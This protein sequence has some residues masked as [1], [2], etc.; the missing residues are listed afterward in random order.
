VAPGIAEGVAL[1]REAIASGRALAK[2]HQFIARTQ[3][4]ARA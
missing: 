2:L 4:L 3:E 1:A